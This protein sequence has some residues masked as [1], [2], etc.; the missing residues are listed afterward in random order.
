MIPKKLNKIMT[1]RG[2]TNFQLSLMAQIST[3]DI[4]Q[5]RNGKK[6][7]FPSWRKRISESLNI[8]ENDLF[9]EYHQKDMED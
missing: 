7:C 8:A 4:S 9:P 6:P 1:E 2:I 5:F 3:A